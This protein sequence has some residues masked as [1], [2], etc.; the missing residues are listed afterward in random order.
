MGAALRR[1]ALIAIALGIVGHQAKADSNEAIQARARFFTDWTSYPVGA[2]INGQQMIV[3]LPPI[4][5]M[6]D[7]SKKY[8]QSSISVTGD[9]MMALF[10]CAERRLKFVSR[11]WIS[12]SPDM[13]LASAMARVCSAPRVFDFQ[14][15]KYIGTKAANPAETESR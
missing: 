6:M 10:D 15:G 4:V 14:T 9:F 5:G 2:D 12:P 13:L 3:L 1:I 8:R 11:P 7:Q